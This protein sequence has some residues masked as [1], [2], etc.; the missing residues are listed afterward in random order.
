MAAD[1]HIHTTASDGS[2]SPAE[3]VEAALRAGLRAIAITDHDSVSGLG[4]AQSRAV[5]RL[6]VIPGVEINTDAKVDGDWVEV[7]ILGYLIDPTAPMFEEELQQLRVLRF[8]RARRIVERLNALNLP[9]SF[10]RVVEI[11]G[12]GPIGRPH[13]AQA[14][15]EAG[16]VGSVLQAFQLYLGVGRPAYV[17]RYKLSPEDAIRLIHAAGGVAVLAHPGLIGDDSLIPA[18]VAAGLDGLEVHYPEHGRH[19]V[20]RYAGLARRFGLVA[21]GGS[22]AHGP[23]FPGRA[24]IGAVRVPDGV[25]DE[26]AARRMAGCR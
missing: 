21:T 20:R 8:E 23:D 22:D 26:L 3:V 11:A 19:E 17:E 6:R 24:P 18:L 13:V 12:T 7:H 5:G 2:L 15:V 9:V 14:M 1:L 25:I 4:E 10:A 16:L